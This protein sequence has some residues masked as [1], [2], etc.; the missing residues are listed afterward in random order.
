[1]VKDGYGG[2][3]LLSLL[4]QPLKCFD[5][6]YA[7]PHPVYPILGIKAGASFTLNQALCSLSHSPPP[8]SPALLQLLLKIR[9][10]NAI[11]TEDALC[12]L[13]TL[14]GS[15]WAGGCS[16]REEA[17]RMSGGRGKKEPNI[18]LSAFVLT[19]GRTSGGARLG[20]H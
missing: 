11:L 2:F 1:M 9:L 12:L 20:V 7:P 18:H 15:S 4:L 14:E 19:Q 8:H 16:S 17:D 3:E 10:V 6:R 13:G 5:Y